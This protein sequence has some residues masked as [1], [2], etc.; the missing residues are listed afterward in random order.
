MSNIVIGKYTLES[1]TSGMYSDP[2]IIYREYVQNASDSIDEALEAGVL[3]C[4]NDQIDIYLSPT[5]RHICICDNGLGILASDVERT[6]IS[7][8]NSKK[9]AHNSRGF[10]GIGRLSGLSYCAKLIFET[11]AYNESGGT[12]VVIDAHKL[13]ELLASEEESDTTVSEVLQTVYK[14]EQF[15]ENA[16][17]HYF[18]V[19]MDGVDDS[20]KLNDFQEV[21]TYISQNAPVPYGHDGFAWGKEITRR[22]NQ[23]GFEI[24]HYNIS[25]TYGNKTVYV[26]KP[27]KDEFLVDKGK[28]L[29]DRIEDISIIKI[30]PEDDAFYAIGWI[31]KTNYFGS[32]YDKSIKGIRLR[33]GNILIGDS[34]T[35]NVVFKDARFNGWSIGE[36]FAIDSK[37]IPNARRDNFEK[38]TAYMLLFEYMTNIASGI[39]KDIRTASLKRN[40]ELSVAL[41]NSVEFTQSAT[42]V[43]ENGVDS[44]DKRFIRQKLA[45]AQEA[46]ANSQLND[47]TGLYYQEIAF[48]EL[49]MLIGKLQ[50]ATSFKA[51]NTIA[52]L[53]KTEKKILEKV[54]YIIV[55]KLGIEADNLVDAI[56][57]EFAKKEVNYGVN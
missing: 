7:I 41:N 8:G 31:A 34:Q 9:N 30:S 48:E 6:L 39:T 43:I 25:V 26:Y 45:S 18:K 56:I 10:R 29:F 49:D 50:G 42:R 24:H 15:V 13:S 21:V 11:S 52:G 12:R 27:Y 36:V 37:L 35:L 1:L 51:I 3:K 53:S 46:I 40:S 38:N 33:K 28:N 19:K 23:E 5:E 20:L 22:L 54:L 4:G 57:D 44:S 47:D 14:I 2:Y 55:N 16:S 32:I 17:A